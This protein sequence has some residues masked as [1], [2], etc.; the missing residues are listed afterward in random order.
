MNVFSPTNRFQTWDLILFCH[1]FCRYSRT[2]ASVWDLLY[3]QWN[4]WLFWKFFPMKYRWFHCYSHKHSPNHGMFFSIFCNIGNSFLSFPH[5]I[6]SPD[7]RMILILLT[8]PILLHRFPIDEIFR[9]CHFLR[10]DI[11]RSPWSITKWFSVPYGL[12]GSVEKKFLVIR[13]NFSYHSPRSFIR[14]P[15]SIF[16]S[17]WFPWILTSA[18][19]LPRAHWS[20]RRYERRRPGNT[21]LH[22]SRFCCDSFFF[23]ILLRSFRHCIRANCR[24]EMG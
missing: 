2:I 21:I 8:I 24:T 7:S 10:I 11:I 5:L 12:R 18:M 6:I 1:K 15:R 4:S 19:F 13:S 20:W 16:S 23:W 3:S 9:S 22:R 17:N 14:S